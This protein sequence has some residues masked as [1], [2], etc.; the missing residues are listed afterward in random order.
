MK[1]EQIAQLAQLQFKAVQQ[2]ADNEKCKEIG[3]KLF[4]LLK[5][6]GGNGADVIMTLVATLATLI[7]S[8]TKNQEHLIPR[9]DNAKVLVAMVAVMLTGYVD[10]TASPEGQKLKKKARAV[11]EALA[12]A[13][14]EGA[15]V[16]NLADF[17]PDTNKPN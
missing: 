11:S 16:I 7:D 4:D 17:M 12:N 8:K 9:E 13:G 10:V 5:E 2:A 15:E 3:L 1:N 6:C 14:Q